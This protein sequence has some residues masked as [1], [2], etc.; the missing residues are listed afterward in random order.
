[1]GNG[2]ENSTANVVGVE[3]GVGGRDVAEVSVNDNEMPPITSKREMAPMMNPL[4]NWRRAF[5]IRSPFLV[6]PKR[7]AA[8]R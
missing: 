7:W 6:C 2:E 1:M 5:M 4:P 3:D 8:G